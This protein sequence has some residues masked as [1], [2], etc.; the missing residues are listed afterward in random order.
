MKRYAEA[1]LFLL[2]S[3]LFIHVVRTAGVRELL[4]LFMG[5]FSGWGWTG[6]FI[7]AFM[8]AWDVLGWQSVFEP[9]WRKR[10]TFL[11][12]YGIRLAGEAINN[13]TP[14]VDIG[15][16]PLKI[17]WLE[18]FLGIPH[19]AA[20]RSCVL[21]RSALFVSEIIFVLLGFIFFALTFPMAKEWQTGL[22][23]GMLL[24]MIAGIFLIIVLRSFKRFEC[25]AKV[26]FRAGA[27]HFIGWVSGGIEMFVLFK[28]LGAP[29]SFL[30]ALVLEAML[31]LIRITSFM[32]PGNLG[33]QE[34]GM[35]FLAGT[36]GCPPQVGV[37]VS[38]L[39]RGR[40][41]LW[42]GVGFALWGFVKF[43]D[44]RKTA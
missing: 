26:F 31:Q 42:S 35:V 13:V 44:K 33:A 5:L 14:I 9:E 25:D 10:V 15:G 17:L 6:L 22:V 19:D 24:F 12:L 1:L 29:V 23:L 28:I 40:Q 43:Y 39:K 16:E 3:I 18:K 36:L 11:R 4:S 20:L 34:G 27:F 30:E 8:C 2:G 7:Y 32:I 41:I 37:A 21:S 38:L